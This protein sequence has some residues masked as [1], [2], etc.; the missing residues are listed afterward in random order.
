MAGDDPDHATRDLF[1]AIERGDYPT[2]RVCIQ[3]MT[4]AQAEQFPYNPFDLTKVWPHADFP[5]MEIGELVLNRNPQNYFQDI[6]QAAFAP[7]NIVPGI[8]FSPDKM[9]QARLFSYPDAHRYRLGPNYEQLP[10]N[11]PHATQA[12]N[13]QRDGAMR[14]D[15]N[16]GGSV[17]YEP[18]SFNGP[19]ENPAYRESAFELSG[20][21][22]R[23][24]HRDGNDDYTQAGDLFRLMTSDEQARLIDHLVDHMRSVPR[25][26]Q[27]RQVCHFFRADP[28]YGAGVANG[29]GIEIEAEV[30]V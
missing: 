23:Y 11:C 16:G 29:L 26:I 22:D 30:A 3:L 4:E 7:A 20:M 24:S 21:V 14:F 10:V 17:N 15:G 2:W 1:E 13:Y 27:E 5:L 8:G 12:R 6:E 28:A 19:A 25:H 9:L 18:N